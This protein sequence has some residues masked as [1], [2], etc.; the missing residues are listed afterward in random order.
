VR[1]C[2]Q[3]IDSI[4]LGETVQFEKTVTE[5]DVYMFAGIT[6]D[7][8]PVHVN[9]E[10]MKRTRFEGRIAHGALILRLASTASSQFAARANIPGVSAGYDRVRFLGPIRFGGTIR[11][12]YA[13]RGKDRARPPLL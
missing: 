9:E 8:A 5:A 11:V 12:D 1:R 6:G 7:F 10:C 2:E 3:I 13:L 4:Q